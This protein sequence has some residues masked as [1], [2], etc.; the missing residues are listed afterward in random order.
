[1]NWQLLQNVQPNPGVIILVFFKNQCFFG[2]LLRFKDGRESVALSYT[3][4]SILNLKEEI[5]AAYPIDQLKK[6][7]AMWSLFVKP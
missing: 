2:R 6:A 7:G 5:V 1:M 4:H 3:W